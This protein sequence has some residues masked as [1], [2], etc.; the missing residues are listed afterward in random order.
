MI[1]LPFFARPTW[2]RPASQKIA[3]VSAR[4]IDAS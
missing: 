3:F 2:K 4:V 1:K